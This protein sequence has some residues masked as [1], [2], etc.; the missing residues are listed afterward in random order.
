LRQQEVKLYSQPGGTAAATFE[1][2]VKWLEGCRYPFTVEPSDE[3]ALRSINDATRVT[4]PLQIRYAGPRLPIVLS[5]P[6]PNPNPTTPWTQL[7]FTLNF[8]ED[9]PSGIFRGKLSLMD[10]DRSVAEL[11]FNITLNRMRLSFPVYSQT[12]R[13]SFP[14]VPEPQE[15]SGAI[16][17]L[18]FFDRA[19]TR[20]ILVENQ[21]GHAM[22]SEHLKVRFL[23]DHLSAG[24]AKLRPPTT[25]GVRKVQEGVGN[26][27][28]VDL[29]FF[30]VRH[31]NPGVPYHIDV[32]FEYRNEAT[33]I[34]LGSMK[35]GID[36]TIVDPKS[37]VL[38]L[39]P[40]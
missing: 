39:R 40:N 19:T 21:L 18:Q 13:E 2:R 27:L 14:A 37:A 38:T 9:S 36:V 32:V 29:T 28:L 10:D 7:P 35:C 17:V 20:T 16:H 24:N 8:P 26:S 31:G 22:S 30:S 11:S 12:V 4:S 15:V 33:G 3:I 1:A 25:E 5:V 6:K 34:D 23:A